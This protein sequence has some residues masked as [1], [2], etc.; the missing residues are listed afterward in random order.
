MNVANWRAESRKSNVEGRS[1]P[2]A[3]RREPKAD[4]K[5][6]NLRPRLPLVAVRLTDS[7]PMQPSILRRDFLFQ[8]GVGSVAFG[9]LGSR[10]VAAPSYKL[11]LGQWS[12]HRALQKRT[13]DNLDFVAIARE[14][15]FD[16]VDYVNQ[17]FKDKAQDLAYLGEMKRRAAG[18]GVANVLILIDGEGALGSPDKAARRQAIENHKRW[19]D[20]AKVLGCRGIRVN[21]ESEGS[22]AEQRKLVV[23]GARGLT[24]YA[25]LHDI[26]ILIE[27]HGGISSDGRWLAAVVKDVNHPRCGSLPDFGNWDMGGGKWYDRYDGVRELLPTAKAIS[28]KAHAFDA[29]GNETETDYA[30]MLK[31]VIDGGYRGE[32]LEIEYEGDKLG[33]AEG[34]RATKALVERT[35]AAL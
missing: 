26:D 1:K 21:A 33:E 28:V 8:L 9:A 5:S 6:G 30:K 20:A 24:E 2:N 7:V 23:E 15:G 17:F 19:V 22:P 4:P 27:N 34:I 13:L 10:G 18:A 11:A 32:F 16:G 3:A 12:F 14:L 35:L 29:Q 31:I 25:A